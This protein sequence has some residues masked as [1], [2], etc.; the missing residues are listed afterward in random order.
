MS[1]S[2]HSHIYHGY[3][4]TQGPGATEPSNSL[5]PST[6]AST[7]PFRCKSFKMWTAMNKDA[8][9]PKSK[10]RL[11]SSYSNHIYKQKKKS[12]GHNTFWLPEQSS[13]LAVWCREFAAV[14][15]AHRLNHLSVKIWSQLSVERKH[16]QGCKHKDLHVAPYQNYLFV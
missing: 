9:A 1:V 3:A 15:D 7:I 5:L 6:T 16:Q 11:K 4:H 14:E 10:L 8:N 12:W 13:S 2:T